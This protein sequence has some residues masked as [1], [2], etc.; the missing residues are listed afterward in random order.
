MKALAEELAASP[1]LTDKDAFRALAN[2]VKDRTGLKGKNLFHPIRVILT[3]SHEGPELDLIVPAIDRAAALALDSGL[4][5]VIGLPRTRRRSRSTPLNAAPCAE[6]SSIYCAVSAGISAIRS[7]LTT[8]RPQCRGMTAIIAGTPVA[9]IASD[10]GLSRE[11]D[12]IC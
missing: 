9:L 4:A 2:R 7:G 12:R 8:I 6:Y 3:G 1:R 10:E 5:P 11:E